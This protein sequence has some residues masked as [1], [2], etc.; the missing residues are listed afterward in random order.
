MKSLKE[1]IYES[2]ADELLKL[3]AADKQRL[4]D[5]DLEYAKLMLIIG[6]EVDIREIE[7]KDEEYEKFNDSYIKK[8]IKYYPV[9]KFRE[10]DW[11]K[12]NI[13][14]RI[15]TLIGEFENLNCILSKYYIEVL[16]LKLDKIDTLRK[17]LS[18]IDDYNDECQLLLARFD[19]ELIKDALDII[20][21]Q[22]FK[23]RTEKKFKKTIDAKTVA[24][25]IEKAL[26]DLGYD[27]SIELVPNMLPRMSV[28]S[29]KILK[30]KDGAMFSEVDVD[31]LIAHEVKG[32]VAKRFYGYQT[33]LFLF[34]YGCWGQNMY[35]EGM[36]IWNTLNIIDEPKPNAMFKIAMA[37]I[38]SYYCLK[39]DF[40]EVFDKI[41]E[42]TKGSDYSDKA[43]F[44]Q[45]IRSKR[46]MVRTERL[47]CW[48]GDIDY[49]RGYKAVEKMT[50]K[51]RDFV[52]KH[53]I[54]PNQFFEAETIDKFLKINKFKPISKDIMEEYIK[55][56]DTINKQDKN[57]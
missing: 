50:D 30:I 3:S 44:S 5:L 39:Y 15:K 43:L 42:L 36:A 14:N 12:Y 19:D 47:G 21:N 28:G 41:K 49:F 23:K 38:V 2:Y 22:P 9:L 16:E 48:A 55:E 8:G 52:L 26:D 35:D 1:Y 34:V 7:N 6:K 17:N 53:N 46:R 54:S 57:Y 31:S 27:W 25:K 18:N 37:Y 32:H 13:E 40:H 33:G 45:L 51:E 24:K 4:I 10:P 29:D 56:R 20:K 11:E